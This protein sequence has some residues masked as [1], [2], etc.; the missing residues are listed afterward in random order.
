MTRQLRRPA[1]SATV[2]GIGTDVGR[3]RLPLPNG[4][5]NGRLCDGCRWPERCKRDGLCWAAEK[6][7]IASEALR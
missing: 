6:R 2:L 7:L 3:G 4:L 5:V 1:A